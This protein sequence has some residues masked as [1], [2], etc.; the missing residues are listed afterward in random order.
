MSG[1]IVPLSGK[2]SPKTSDT[3][4]ELEVE[5]I[6]AA[7]RN[8][9][10]ELDE[11]LSRSLA[12]RL[13]LIGRSSDYVS[14]LSSSPKYNYYMLERLQHALRKLDAEEQRTVVRALGD[15]VLACQ[16]GRV[17]QVVSDLEAISHK[18]HVERWGEYPVP[19][20]LPESVPVEDLFDPSLGI[21]PTDFFFSHWRIYVRERLLVR[22]QLAK[23]D[24]GLKKALDAEYKGH[25]EEY[26]EL[27]PRLTDR[28]RAEVRAALGDDLSPEELRR[29]T[30]NLTKAKSAAKRF[31][32][33]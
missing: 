21:N 28:N 9:Y 12:S 24:P 10:L 17:G 25:P 29:Q 20:E 30:K 4:V 8:G 3:S 32:L 31:K 19:K 15:V 6:E 23:L 13:V 1:K 7:L 14:E 16:K 33:G 18:L 5:Q 26:A 27:L 2:I 11:A 22:P